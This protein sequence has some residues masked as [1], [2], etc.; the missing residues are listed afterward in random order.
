M[1]G[2]AGVGFAA[3]LDRGLTDTPSLTFRYWRGALATEFILGFDWD[4]GR[5]QLSDMQ[6]F[7][8]GF[9][10]L[11]MVHDSPHLSVSVGGRLYIQFTSLQ[12]ERASVPVVIETSGE[13]RL[14]EKPSRDQLDTGALL[15]L[16][17][18]VEY[19]LSDHSAIT[20][21][22]GITLATV[23]T[24]VRSFG[25]VGGTGRPFTQRDGITVQLA[26]QYSGGVGYTYYF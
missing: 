5:T 19:F 22:V 4:V 13:V 7:H 20:A 25:A 23:G 2:K 8:G 12:Q 11:W 16:P 21:S 3:R 24:G 9:G 18:Q 6:R 15:A 14:T 10:A 1:T 26:G 17:M